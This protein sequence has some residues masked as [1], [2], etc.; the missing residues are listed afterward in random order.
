MTNIINH[1]CDQ[2]K[3]MW[4]LGFSTLLETDCFDGTLLNVMLDAGKREKAVILPFGW[5]T[6]I[7]ICLGSFMLL[8]TR[9]FIR[10]RLAQPVYE[11]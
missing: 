5:K 4:I 6:D 11:R 7:L 1:L 3:Q 9:D 8:E 10:Y 2:P